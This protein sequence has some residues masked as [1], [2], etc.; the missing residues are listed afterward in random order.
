MS[1]LKLLKLLCVA[2]SAVLVFASLS[3][4]GCSGD[5]DDDDDVYV[6]CTQFS[7]EEDCSANSQCRWDSI[8][9][10]L[11]RVYPTSDTA[12]A[13][14]Y[15]DTSTGEMIGGDDTN[16]AS[17]SCVNINPQIGSVAEFNC[18]DYLADF[19]CADAIPGYEED[20]DGNCT[21]TGETVNYEGYV[22]SFSFD[23]FVKGAMVNAF[24][25]PICGESDPASGK[26]EL[27]NVPVDENGFI[28]LVANKKNFVPSYD[29]NK[30]PYD[31]EVNII[32]STLANM[33]PNLVFESF[34]QD[35]AIIAGTVYDSVD[36][37]NGIAD[38][39]VTISPSGGNRYYTKDGKPNADQLLT[40][41]DSSI[42]IFFAVPPAEGTF[43]EFAYT[44]TA[45]KSGQPVGN[46][47]KVDTFGGGITITNIY[48][49]SAAQ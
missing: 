47:V 13:S 33:L 19:D 49:D 30:R 3:F 10:D 32:N 40:E 16:T 14:D 22:I 29:M 2:A 17:G 43:P 15:P 5:D 4:V 38:C 28:H 35:T 36:T 18:E 8:I 25:S 1:A 27:K 31:N 7:G 20:A 42:F 41:P 46:P 34:G 37:E 48:Q 9:I 24:K 39:D 6:D 44:L 23:E 12:D 45:T 11:S 26:I 21:Y